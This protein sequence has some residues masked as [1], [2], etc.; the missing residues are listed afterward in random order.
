MG[1]DKFIGGEGSFYL[2]ICNRCKH[3]L[4]Y[5][6]CKAFPEEIPDEIIRGKIDHCS[7]L[8]GQENDLT[9][10]PGTETPN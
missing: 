3:Y 6:K 9:F 10:Q 1:I 7:P 2:P 4:G 5:L 8:P